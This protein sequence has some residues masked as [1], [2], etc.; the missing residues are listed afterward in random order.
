M[1]AI[2]SGTTHQLRPSQRLVF[3][4]PTSQRRF[5]LARPVADADDYSACC[6]LAAKGQ[7]A[8]PNRAIHFSSST[9]ES[10]ERSNSGHPVGRREAIV[11]ENRIDRT[12]LLL[13]PLD[14]I[15]AG[16]VWLFAR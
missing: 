4:T 14:L 2:A 12:G 6:R 1:D 5:E 10:T 16:R 7:C 9:S 3:E 11:P 13:Q 15:E 8:I